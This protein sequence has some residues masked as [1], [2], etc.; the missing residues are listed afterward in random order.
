MEKF[1][2]SKKGVDIL[3]G[4]FG[5]Q[6]TELNESQ[7]AEV[8]AKLDR[9]ME[10]RIEAK[11]KFQTEVI[12]EEAKEKYDSLLTEATSKFEKDIKSMEKLIEEKA[13]NYKQSL[14]TKFKKIVENVEKKKAKELADYKKVM[15]EKLDK[16]L[17][18][19][20]QKS[21]P[22]IYVEA[23]AKVEVLEP[24]VEA[25]KR[26]LNENY[27]K[28]DENN[29]GILKDAKKEIVK[30]R[31]EVAKTTTKNMDLNSELSEVKRSS[32]ISKVC[33]GLTV[34][35]REKAT[36]ILESYD[37][38]EVEERFNAV[39][40]LIIESADADADDKKKKPVVDAKKSK[41]IPT[42]KTPKVV[43]TEK[44]L[45]EEDD[46]VDGEEEVVNETKKPLTVAPIKESVS[47]EESE[48]RM[49]LEMAKEF[50]K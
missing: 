8:S 41:T 48:R 47:K 28:F 1:L 4:L 2:M 43:A 23:Y 42:D 40:D 46:V 12:E 21:V 35:Q 36:R 26:S 25:V 14:T 45:K 11:V 7:T 13:I 3:K 33:E 19:E 34:T 20:M 31:E 9:L 18:L 17:D 5:D 50:R 16:Y 37:A 38:S 27:I 49:I 44:K 10:S 30:L 39:R 29:I 15:V 6:V 32:I 24:I 22:D